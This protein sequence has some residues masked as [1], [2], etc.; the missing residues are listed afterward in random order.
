MLVHDHKTMKSEVF[1]F[2]ETAPS[3]ATPDM[4]GNDRTKTRVVSEF[5]F[6]KAI[7]KCFSQVSNAIE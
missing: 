6:Y 2:R 4:F 1:D 3:A 7:V 5:S